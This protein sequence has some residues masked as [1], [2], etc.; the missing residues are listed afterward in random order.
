MVRVGLVM[1]AVILL[2]VPLLAAQTSQKNVTL[3]I[4]PYFNI[5]IQRD[6]EMTVH[7]EDFYQGSPD[8]RNV[9]GYSGVTVHCNADAAIWC[10][11]TTPVTNDSGSYSMDCAL[12][13]SGPNPV[14]YVRLGDVDWLRLPVDPG[15]YDGNDIGLNVSRKQLWTAA[16]LAGVY[17]GR[18]W[19][20][21]VPQG[22]SSPY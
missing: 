4:D 20:Y 17:T 2:Q 22:S 14:G 16:D 5:V 7:T 9:F 15:A 13:L 3:T 8:G 18:V 10:L 12:S 19:L 1:A 11:A 21:I 6:I